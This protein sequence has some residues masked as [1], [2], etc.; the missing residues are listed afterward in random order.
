MNVLHA[1]IRP[2]PGQDPANSS[3]DRVR[4]QKSSAREA[5]GEAATRQGITFKSLDRDE[6]GAPLPTDGQY[7]SITH[8]AEYVAGVAAAWPLG[9]DIERMRTPSAEVIAEAASEGEIAMVRQRFAIC[10]VEAFTRIWSA[11]EALLKLTGE[12]LC[13]LS[14]C[15]IGS[16]SMTDSRPGLWVRYERQEHFVHQMQRD[17]H[18]ASVTCP[19]V[20]QVQWDWHGHLV[21]AGGDR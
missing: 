18:I 12:G 7:W 9:I 4:H 19:Q 14:K 8:T 10:E 1:V 2:T 11:K 16:T 5:L 15:T 13:G 20:Q 6:H 17:E 21:G 3:R